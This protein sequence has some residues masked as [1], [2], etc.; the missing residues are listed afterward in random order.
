MKP[1]WLGFFLCRHLA[2]TLLWTRAIFCLSGLILLSL[3]AFNENSLAACEEAIR[4]IESDSRACRKAEKRIEGIAS[5]IAATAGELGRFEGAAAAKRVRSEYTKHHTDIR[6]EELMALTLYCDREVEACTRAC[7]GNPEER[8]CLEVKGREQDR[9][10]LEDQLAEEK[11]RAEKHE[12]DVVNGGAGE[13]DGKEKKEEDGG[14]GEGGGMPQLPQKEDKPNE[15]ID[16]S[17]SGSTPGPG[18]PPKDECFGE[19]A[20]SLKCMCRGAGPKPPECGGDPKERTERNIGGEGGGLRSSGLG[21]MSSQSLRGGSSITPGASLRRSPKGGG[22]NAATGGGG[23]GS[24][25][26]RRSGGGRVAGSDPKLAGKTPSIHSGSGG[27]RS[28]LSGLS[29]S[30]TRGSADSPPGRTMDPQKYEKLAAE[31]ATKA[32][33]R[34]SGVSLNGEIASSHTNLFENASRAYRNHAP[35][36]KR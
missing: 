24:S 20:D 12:K 25:P 10:V 27:G 29:G 28:G 4:E 32:L 3:L 5:A 33:R 23:G 21:K 30:S 13:G 18:C 15:K 16:L 8:K 34:I 17:C 19:N 31:G 35:R 1:Q 6:G 22:V 7:E 2:E 36:M 11:E 14:G 9:Q 26:L